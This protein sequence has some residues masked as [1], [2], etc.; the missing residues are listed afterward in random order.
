MFAFGDQLGCPG[1]EVGKNAHDSWPEEV[2]KMP[3]TVGQRKKNQ[4][5]VDCVIVLLIMA[6]NQT[7]QGLVLG[8]LDYLGN[9]S[10]QYVR[11]AYDSTEQR[12]CTETVVPDGTTFLVVTVIYQLAGFP[13]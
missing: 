3:M 11:K 7:V 10:L 4:D 9:F 1:R 12:C 6:A 8:F 5:Q 2:G 13:W